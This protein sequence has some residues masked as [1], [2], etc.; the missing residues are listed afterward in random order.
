MLND[1]E[2]IWHSAYTSSDNNYNHKGK[3]YL[4]ISFTNPEDVDGFIYRARPTGKNGA[5]KFL[6]YFLGVSSENIP[7]NSMIREF[8]G[9][10]CFRV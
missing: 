6:D 10:S 1:E 4:E 9:G 2:S 8:V 7:H 5:L 3:H